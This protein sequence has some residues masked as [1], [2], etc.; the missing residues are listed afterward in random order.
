MKFWKAADLQYS[1]WHQPAGLNKY[2]NLL[3]EYQ[4]TGSENYPHSDHEKSFSNAQ[5]QKV[6]GSD[7]VPQKLK[8][9]GVT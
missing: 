8:R 4:A 1:L 6:Q 5:L 7:R 3:A 9:N 2:E